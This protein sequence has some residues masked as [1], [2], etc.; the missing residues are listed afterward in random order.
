MGHKVFVSYKY[1]DYKVENLPGQSY[2]TV[3]DYVDVLEEKLGKDNV[4]KGEQDGEDL[5]HLNEATIWNKL[6]ERI[7]DSTVTIVLV[8]KGMKEPNSY[9]KS[10]WIPWEVRYS[11]C[12]Y[13]KDQRTSHTNGLLYVVLPDVLGN[14]DYMIEDKACCSSGCKMFHD[15]D[16]FYI[17]SKN[18]FNRIEE[19]SWKCNIGDTVHKADDSYAIMIKW[20]DFMAS[21]LMMNLMIDLAY[22][23]AQHKSDYE[24]RT[25]INRTD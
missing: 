5:S 17:M 13:S 14:Y 25:K 22:Q 7:Y 2:S 4:Y 12:E 3:R 9:D 6:K 23:R 1:H 15:N 8:S 20:K 16:L 10:Q 18:L 19:N 21:D 24:L 11:L